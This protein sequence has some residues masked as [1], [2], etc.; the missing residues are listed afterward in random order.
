MN[1]KSNEEAIEFNFHDLGDCNKAEDM[2]ILNKKKL[3]L[4]EMPNLNIQ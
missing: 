3:D 1:E 2:Q 4:S